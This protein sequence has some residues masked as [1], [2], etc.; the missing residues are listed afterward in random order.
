MIAGDAKLN[1]DLG[2]G[3]LLVKTLDGDWMVWRSVSAGEQAKLN[4]C[5]FG[6]SRKLYSK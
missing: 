6:D 4:R 5:F 2:V 3:R 1:L